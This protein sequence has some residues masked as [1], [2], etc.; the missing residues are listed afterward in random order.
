MKDSTALIKESVARLLLAKRTKEKAE[1]YY[2]EVRKKNSLQSAI[3]CLATFLK[4][5]VHLK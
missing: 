3:I 4:M 1:K 2:N 5:K